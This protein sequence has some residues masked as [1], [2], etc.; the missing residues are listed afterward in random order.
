MK[1]W[2][3]AVCDDHKEMLDIFVNNVATTHHYLL[4]KDETINTWLQL[5]YG[6]SLR[7]IHHDLDM[8]ACFN[9]GYRMVEWSQK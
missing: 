5:H 8:D 2:Y 1:T 9:K 3:K 7:L 4:D 6:C